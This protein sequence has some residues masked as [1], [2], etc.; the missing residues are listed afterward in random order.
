MRVT[1]MTLGTR[2]DVQPFVT[3]AC[4]LRDLGHEVTVSS[5]SS[6]QWIADEH[7]V[8][9]EPLDL[10]FSD[11]QNSDGAAAAMR[12]NVKAVINAMRTVKP[13]FRTSLTDQKRVVES[14]SPEL[15]ISH[16]KTLGGPHLAEW[17]GIPHVGSLVIPGVT[18][19]GEFPPIPLTWTGTPAWLNRFAYQMIPMGMRSFKGIVADFRQDELGLGGPT[20]LWDGAAPTMY[21]Y[22]PTAVPNPDDWPPTAQ[23]VGYWLPETPASYEAPADL[24]DFIERGEPPVYI[25]FGSSIDAD[26]AALGGLIRDA[27]DRADV[28]AVVQGGRQLVHIE[29]SDAVLFAESV[30]HSWLF[31][32]MSCIVHH[33]GS[34][35][36]GEA[37]RAAK[38]QVVVPFSVD[39]PF[40]AKRVHMLGV[41][42][43][44]LPRKKLTSELLARSIATARSDPTIARAGE[45]V[46]KLLQAEDG[47]AAASDY[48]GAIANGRT[49]RP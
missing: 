47:V 36:T 48:L 18:T 27:V 34:G 39:Q 23:A 22:S 45:R 12:G 8:P 10:D 29:S 38:P 9:Y 32:Q 41:S 16:P 4:G 43:E 20:V 26:P 2:G 1:I 17:L 33:G 13:L 42:P 35:T 46:G 11:L 40:W 49:P 7:G 14:T 37:L 15:L 21:G 28:R 3:L 30:P 24:V 19:T 5:S 25:G 44:P 31:P 6:F